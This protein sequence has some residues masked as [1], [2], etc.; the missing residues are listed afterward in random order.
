MGYLQVF[1]LFSK[2]EVHYENNH[3]NLKLRIS[4]APLD[5]QAQGTSLFTR[6]AQTHYTLASCVVY[7]ICRERDELM[8][9]VLSAKSVC[10]LAMHREA[11]LLDQLLSF[12]KDF[13]T[14]QLEVL[15]VY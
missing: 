14:A 13:E 3:R 10:S 15:E 8:E 1:L 7:E 5:C 12:I 9:R 6:A 2:S 4:K 11:N